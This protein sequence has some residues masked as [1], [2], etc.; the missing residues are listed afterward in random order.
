MGL[1]QE[2]GKSPNV[3]SALRITSSLSAQL[4]FLMT[5]IT[6]QSLVGYLHRQSSLPKTIP[7][8]NLSTQLWHPSSHKSSCTL[9]IHQIMQ[10]PE[11]LLRTTSLIS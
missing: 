10:V 4:S 1:L 7:R 6:I 5:I 3:V 9:K 2:R 8:P 11:T